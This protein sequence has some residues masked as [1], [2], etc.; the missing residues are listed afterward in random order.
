M[1]KWEQ[2]IPK[3]DGFGPFFPELHPYDYTSP[4]SQIK[5]RILI[6]LTKKLIFLVKYGLFKVKNRPTNKDQ[7]VRDQVSTIFTEASNSRL[8]L[9]ENVLL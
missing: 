3:V 7:Q 9:V 8:T 2:D 1:F 5:H 4:R 6:K